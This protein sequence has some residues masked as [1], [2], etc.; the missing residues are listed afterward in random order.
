LVLRNGDLLHEFYALGKT[1]ETVHHIRSVTKSILSALVG[2][3]VEQ[4]LIADIDSPILDI[5]PKPL[6]GTVDPKLAQVTMRHLLTMTAG[7]VWDESDG[8]AVREWFFGGKQ[9][10]LTDALTRPIR[11]APGTVFN[12]DSPTADLLATLLAQAVGRDLQSFARDY[13]FGPLGIHDFRWEQDPAGNYRESAGLELRPIDLAKLGQLYLQQGQWQ[14][15]Q[16]MPAAWVAASVV[17]R[18]WSIRRMA[19][20]TCGGCR[21]KRCPAFILLWALAASLSWWHRT[22]SL[23]WWRS[24]SGGRLGMT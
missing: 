4:G 5:L 11:H 21:R 6:T 12:Y 16:L 22:N 8:P 23:S 13:L 24:M 3:A 20:A 2:I 14:G 18:R 17:T 1:R 15:Q 10:V 7:F 19:M 9:T